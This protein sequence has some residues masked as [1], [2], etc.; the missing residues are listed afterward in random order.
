MC[1]VTRINALLFPLFQLK[2]SPDL[3]VWTLLDSVCNEEMSTTRSGK[4]AW[5]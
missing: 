3:K 4:L 5:V 2:Y 1:K